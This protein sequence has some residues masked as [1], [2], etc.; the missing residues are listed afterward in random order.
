MEPWIETARCTSCN[1][2]TNING[3]LFAYDDNKQAYIKDA[4]A[5]T[6]AE[7]VQAAE[8]CPAGIIH[9]GDPLNPNEKNLDKWVKRA[10]P[11]N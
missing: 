4:L 7:I 9:P 11:F 6:F 3:R 10:E 8:R 5:G 2:C 1:E